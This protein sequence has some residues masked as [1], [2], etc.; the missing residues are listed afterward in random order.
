MKRQFCYLCATKL[1]PKS[2]HSW[3]CSSCQYTQYENPRPCVELI[4]FHE[5]K[6]L[7]CE[8][9]R[10]PSKGAYDFPGGFVE[11]GE[12]YERAIAREI[13]EE[14]QLNKTDYSDVHYLTSFHTP[15]PF[16]KEVYDNIVAVFTAKLIASPDRVIVSDDVASVRWVTKDQLESI[17][18][19]SAKHLENARLVFLDNI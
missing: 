9:G 15:Y 2:D 17:E 7:I 10:E 18:W 13:Q 4:L 6:I 8:R 16:G 1:E 3:W 14:L 11:C 12:T 5:D 19:A